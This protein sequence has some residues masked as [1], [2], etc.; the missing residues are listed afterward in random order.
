MNRTPRVAATLLC[1]TM[2]LLA[3]G[4][5]GKGPALADP[6]PVKTPDNLTRVTAATTAGIPPRRPELWKEFDGSLAF[7]TA[8]KLAGFGP[9]PSGSDTLEQAREEIS[10]ELARA[11][12]QILPQ[13]FS[14]ADPGGKPVAFRSLSARFTAV[15]PVGKRYVLAAHLDTERSEVVRLPGAT[16]AAAGPAVLLEI[17]RVLV[18]DPQLASRVQLLFLDGHHPFRQPNAHDGLFGSRV[19]APLLAAQADGRELRAVI[20][21]ENLGGK[22]FRLHYAPNSDPTLIEVLRRSA[23]A[24]SIPV[25]PANRP[26][27][28]DQVPFTQA[29]LPALALLDAEAAYVH[30]AD[31]TLDRLDPASLA[32]VGQLVLYFL[33]VETFPP[34]I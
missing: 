4:K 18:G 5:R 12:W 27:L 20:D 14:D 2:A 21:L 11:G 29:N 33:S 31:D 13:A 28:G 24:L 23:E 16:E 15:A 8:L 7:S 10:T 3:C 17:A 9:R 6:S 26:I 34:N 25:A 1:L 32:K 19:A 22:E 30:T